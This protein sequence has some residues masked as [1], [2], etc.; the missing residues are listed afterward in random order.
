MKLVVEGGNPL[1]GEVSVS[2][3]KNSALPIIYA[4]ILVQDECIIHNVPMVSDV[5]N[6]IEILKKM[7]AEAE[8]KE[9]TLVINTK[10]LQGEIKGNDLISQMRASYYLMGTMLSRF[11]RAEMIMPGGCNF[12]HRP[13]ELHLRGFSL[14]GAEVSTDGEFVSI[15]GEKKLKSSK[16]ILDKISV[17]ATINIV[18]ACV[19][20]D[21]IT[22]IDNVAIEPHVDD[23]INFLNC[24]GAKIVRY[25][26][27]IYCEGVKRLHSV[28][29]KIYPW[30]C[31]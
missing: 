15:S 1:K 16:I 6:S 21:G 30:F 7:G 4:T 13:I 3:M 29:Y 27:K 31:P 24:A 8:L 14:L 11:G 9:N 20:L 19:L 26:R 17:G 2:G 10:N 22:V 23:L 18:L 28:E 25:G 12:G 5:L